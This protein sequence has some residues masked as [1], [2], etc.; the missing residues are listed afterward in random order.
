MCEGEDCRKADQTLELVGYH[1]SSASGS[2]TARM[3]S[4]HRVLSSDAPELQGMEGLGNSYVFRSEVGSEGIGAPVIR[5]SPIF[6]YVFFPISFL[7]LCNFL[8]F[9]SLSFKR[10]LVCF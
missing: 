9:P 8:D 6:H 10:K 3:H 7:G 4:S 5:K 2:Q 1:P